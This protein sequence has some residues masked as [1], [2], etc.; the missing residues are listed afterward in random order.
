MWHHDI[1]PA[2]NPRVAPVHRF[3]CGVVDIRPSVTLERK[4][5]SVNNDVF[6]EVRNVD[7]NLYVEDSTFQIFVN[8]GGTRRTLQSQSGTWW[9]MRV[10][11]LAL[12]QVPQPHISVVLR[13]RHKYSG[14]AYSVSKVI[15]IIVLDSVFR[16]SE[17]DRV[18]YTY[19]DKLTPMIVGQEQGQVYLLHSYPQ[20][21]RSATLMQ[22]GANG[23]TIHKV[24]VTGNPYLSSTGVLSDTVYSK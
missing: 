14:S 6:F 3:G 17:L 21:T 19:G 22:I 5:L 23:D 10:N 18:R 16:I 2:F 4:N 11:V 15:P 9:W 24:T 12:P 20:R 7:P 8:D 1:V 13:V